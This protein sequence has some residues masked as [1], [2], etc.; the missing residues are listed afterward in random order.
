MSIEDRIKQ[1]RSTRIT[2]GAATFYITLPGPATVYDVMDGHRS[3]TGK[4]LALLQESV[5]GWDGVRECDILPDGGDGP[6]AYSAS[7]LV[8]LLDM[9]M[10]SDLAA[11]FLAWYVQRIDRIDT[12]KKTPPAS[13]SGSASGEG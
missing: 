1:S 11:Q 7:A 12:A 10:G 9:P 6:V 4:L 2:V 3:S 5:T 13:S 8:A